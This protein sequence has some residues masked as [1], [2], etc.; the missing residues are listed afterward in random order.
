MVSLLSFLGKM[1]LKNQVWVV[2]KFLTTVVWTF[3]RGK[4]MTYGMEQALPFLEPVCQGLIKKGL[5]FV[6][7]KIASA[8]YNFFY[9][10]GLKN[11]ITHFFYQRKIRDQPAEVILV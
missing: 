9:G 5:S 4:L 6:L 3:V 10:N 11:K 8:A 7:G 2:A 1:A